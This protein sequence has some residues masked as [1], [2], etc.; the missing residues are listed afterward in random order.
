MSR[1]WRVAAL[2]GFWTLMGLFLF[3]Q[4]LAQKIISHDTHPWWHH[5]TSWMIGVWLLFV[6]TPLVWWLGKRFPIARKPYWPGIAIHVPISLVFAFV[7]LAVEAAILRAIGV[8]PDIMPS[9]FAT[10]AFLLIIGYH[11]SVMTYWSVLA[12]QYA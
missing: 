2:F 9:F 8:F 12:A 10:L 3:S 6:L 7:D 4:G 5:L 1:A 11:Q